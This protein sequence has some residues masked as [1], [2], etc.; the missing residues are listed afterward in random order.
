M[1]V[2]FQRIYS[3]TRAKMTSR[4]DDSSDL[5]SVPSTYE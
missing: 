2:A 4:A 5:R 3:E 1:Q